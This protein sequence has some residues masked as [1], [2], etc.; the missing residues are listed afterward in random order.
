MG[1]DPEAIIRALGLRIQELRSNQDTQESF[2]VK[3]EMLPSNYARLEQGRTNPTVETLI[4]VADALEV[5]LIELFKQPSG[6]PQKPGRP[7]QTKR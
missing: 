2:A 5:D 1:N 7:K 4:R 6:K 3:V